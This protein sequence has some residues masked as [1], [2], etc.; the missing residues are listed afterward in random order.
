MLRFAARMEAQMDTELAV[1]E[2]RVIDRSAGWA[3]AELDRCL[4]VVWRAQPTAEAFRIR[5]RALVDLVERRGGGCALI[6]V[7]EHTSASP[8]N[9]TRQVAMEV[10]EELGPRL[11]AIGIVLE[12]SQVPDVGE[13]R[14][15]HDD[16]VL[17]QTTAADKG[18]QVDR[19]DHLVGPDASRWPARSRASTRSRT[20]RAP[21][22]DPILA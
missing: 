20:R 11:V 17:R 12:G 14:D 16:D 6:E 18:L 10:F 13:P 7:V 4:L 9:E 5:H 21:S 15:P 2:L 1:H 19:G 22:N 3:M 8:T